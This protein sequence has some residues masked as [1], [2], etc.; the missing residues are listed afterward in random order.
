MDAEMTRTA[1][2]LDAAV[3]ET[4]GV[5]AVYAARPLA[6]RVVGRLADEPQPCAHVQ[7]GRVGVDITVSIAVNARHDGAEVADRVAAGIRSAASS[8]P[9]ERVRV[10]VSRLVT[11]P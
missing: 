9:V 10:R 8:L 4:A 11:D 7:V 5:E 2:A 3:A 1:L 6:A